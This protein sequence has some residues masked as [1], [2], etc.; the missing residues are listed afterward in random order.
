[1]MR[2]L[3][4]WYLVSLPLLGLRTVLQVLAV[5]FLLQW[6]GDS[7][8]NAVAVATVIVWIVERPLYFYAA[9]FVDAKA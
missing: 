4:W 9:R 3:L 1:M 5:A 6:A 7:L 8:S 2:K